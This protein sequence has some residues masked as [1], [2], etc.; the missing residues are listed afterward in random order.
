MGLF[1]SGE[2]TALEL[3]LDRGDVVSGQAVEGRLRIGEPDGKA[4]DGRVDLL[5]VNTYRYDTRDSDGDRVTRTRREDVVV[6]S[7]PLLQDGAL[8][9][10]DV[11]LALPVPPTAPGSA[12]ESVDWLVRAVVD[13]KMASDVVVEAP[14]LVRVPAEPLL[15]W[16]QSPPLVPPGCVVELQVASRVVA[17]G[18]QLSGTLVLRAVEDVKARTVRV[19]LRSV[20]DDPDGNETDVDAGQAVV[21]GELELA[22]GEA[23]AFP[24]ALQVPPGAPPSYAALRNTH[25]WLLEGVV[26][27][28][29]SSDLVGRVELVVHTA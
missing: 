9:T 11:R 5:Y 26:D 22:A 16:S 28:P 27:R 4:R 21:S 10:G 19:Q 6:A 8:R 24:F 29:W 7:L 1:S 20:R 17:P 2:P 15:A 13:R 14:L 25:H 3:V 23:R 18:A 12:P